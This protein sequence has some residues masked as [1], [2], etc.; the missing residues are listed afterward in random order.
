M[1]EGWKRVLLCVA[2]GLIIVI[3]GFWVWFVS[4]PW[5]EPEHSTTVIV[6]IPDTE[7]QLCLDEYAEFRSGCFDIY[8]RVPGRKDRLLDRGDFNEPFCPIRNGEYEIEF[9]ANTATLYYPF[10]ATSNREDWVDISLDL[11]P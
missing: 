5:M 4:T 6:D 11:I 7:N 9:E 8:L 3:I 1:S 2:L 10:S